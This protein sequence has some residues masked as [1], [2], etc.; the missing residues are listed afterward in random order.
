MSEHKSQE[1]RSG[2]CR[3]CGQ[4]MLWAKTES[5][6]SIPLDPEPAP[7]GNVALDGAVAMVLGPEAA[8]QCRAA[9]G[10]LYKSHFA[11]CSHP[12]RH[13]KEQQDTGR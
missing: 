1:P 2:A 6:K 5:G 10:R 7:D 12:E 3:S 4:R 13:R 11:T 8:A 9:G